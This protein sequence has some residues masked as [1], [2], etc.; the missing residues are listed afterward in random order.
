MTNRQAYQAEIEPYRLSRNGV[1]LILSK[2]GF[3][4]ES[5]YVYGDNTDDFYRAVIEGLTKFLTLTKEK[6]AGSENN[7]DIKMLQDRIN[8]YQKK[9]DEE[10]KA[11]FIDRTAEW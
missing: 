1:E 6:D 8:G 9:L 2:Y 11:F 10:E 4:P 7:Y 3:S 5:P